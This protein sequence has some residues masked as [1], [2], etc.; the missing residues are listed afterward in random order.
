[1]RSCKEAVYQWCVCGYARAD[2][3]NDGIPC[4]KQCGQSSKVN[5]ERVQAYKKEFGCR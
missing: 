1:M 2:G 4:E 5:L 3:D